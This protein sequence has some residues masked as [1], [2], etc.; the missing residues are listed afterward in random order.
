M[1][2]LGRYRGFWSLTIEGQV[3]HGI[4]VKK[5]Y[6]DLTKEAREDPR[7]YVLCGGQWQREQ[8]VDR[9]EVHLIG[10]DLEVLSYYASELKRTTKIV[11]SCEVQDTRV[12]PSEVRSKIDQLIHKRQLEDAANATDDAG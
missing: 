2:R 4:D 12:P 5:S 8:E 6:L 9:A 10:P 1:S 11:E 3:D 7:Q